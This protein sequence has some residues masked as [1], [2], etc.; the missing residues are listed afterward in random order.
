[1]FFKHCVIIWRWKQK[2]CAEYFRAL[3]QILTDILNLSYKSCMKNKGYYF[4]NEMNYAD[5]YSAE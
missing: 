5:F 3:L 4:S 2:K 1:M